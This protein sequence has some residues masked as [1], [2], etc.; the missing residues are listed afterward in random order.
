MLDRVENFNLDG[1]SEA[2]FKELDT[3]VSLPNFKPAAVEQVSQAAKSICEWV[4]AV[5]GYTAATKEARET[6]IRMHEIRAQKESCED[7]IVQRNLAL[8][9]IT[10]QL[11]I[12]QHKHSQLLSQQPRDDGA[13][14]A[15]LKRKIDELTN[16]IAE[17][18]PGPAVGT[19]GGVPAHAMQVGAP[20]TDLTSGAAIGENPTSLEQLRAHTAA[21]LSARHHLRELRLAHRAV[22]LRDEERERLG[23]RVAELVHLEEEG[24]GGGL[25]R[26]RAG[27]AGVCGEEHA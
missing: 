14:I 17:S 27:G 4:L 12:L 13:E 19:G 11:S 23:E 7:K 5:H 26:G 9:E 15:S 8:E 25:A 3:Y 22:E 2:T 1:V 18:N 24:D 16:R 20:A 21:I 6:G 10:A